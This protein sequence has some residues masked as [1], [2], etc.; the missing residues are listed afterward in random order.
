MLRS[1]C[2]ICVH[3][4]T[5]KKYFSDW[6]SSE[7]IQP[8][9]ILDLS[10]T[11]VGIGE[12]RTL[13]TFFSRLPFAS[14]QKAALISSDGLTKEAQNALLKTLEETP[15]YGFIFIM[16][17][18]EDV[19]LPTIL[20]RCQI[21]NLQQ[22][23]GSAQSVVDAESLKFWDNLLKNKIA[24]R[25]SQTATLT[26]DREFTK[27]WLTLQIGFFRSQLLSFYKS[28]SPQQLTATK[29]ADILR[30]LQTTYN[31]VNS[32]VNL[33]LALDNMFMRMPQIL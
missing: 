17:T 28:K 23:V 11:K 2:L 33:K 1:I 9:D 13:I 31:Y 10:S 8:V 27:Q 22:K 25:L 3:S 19:L 7:K 26:K 5:G 4:D 24:H 30:Q 6:V 29:C 32:N 14:S 15:K 18:S 20:S 16:A 21:I 12:I